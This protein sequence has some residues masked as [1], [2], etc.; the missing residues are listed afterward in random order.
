MAGWRVG[1]K[2]G[3][4]ARRQ[5]ERV[6]NQGEQRENADGQFHQC[7]EGFVSLAPRSALFAGLIAASLVVFWQPLS[8]LIQSAWQHDEYTHILLVLPITVILI[9]LEGTNPAAVPRYAPAIGL[10]LLGLAAGITEAGRSDKLAL[11]GG[12][13]L[14]LSILALVLVWMACVLFTYG[15]QV[16]RSLLFPLLLLFMI[17]PVPVSLLD[18]AILFLQQGSTEATFLLFKLGGV[19]VLKQG[20]VLS[21]PSLN[22]EVAKQCSGIRSSMMLLV[23]GLV[24]S[25]LF[26]RS[27]WAQV[28]FVFFI[29]PMA[30]IKNAVRIFTLSMLAM[31]V[32]PGFLE[33]RLHRDGG[34][35]F[36][37]LGL[38]AMLGVL[39]LLQKVERRSPGVADTP[40]EGMKPPQG[41]QVSIP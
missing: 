2:Y 10:A 5:R 1:S 40:S 20:F 23:T 37:I 7:G 17:V 16:F 22:I 28:V 38:T 39:L 19:P 14:S 12:G 3:C 4:C 34:I 9:F 26:L 30:V 6:I 36:F 15:T 41:A 31:H 8:L 33:G 29:V 32:D 24:L 13:V 21:M 18:R 11:G 27:L 35:V 25:H